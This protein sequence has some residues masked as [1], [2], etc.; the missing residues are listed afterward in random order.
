MDIPDI[1][2]CLANLS[3]RDRSARVSVIVVLRAFD[4]LDGSN[5]GYSDNGE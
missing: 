1:L 4:A 3:L 5:R 2:S